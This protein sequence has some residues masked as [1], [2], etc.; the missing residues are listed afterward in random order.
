MLLWISLAYQKLPIIARQSAPNH[1]SDADHD[2]PPRYCRSCGT[3][4]LRVVAVGAQ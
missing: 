1:E 2:R 4:N 3:F